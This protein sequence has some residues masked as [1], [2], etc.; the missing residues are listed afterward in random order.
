MRRT[1]VASHPLANLAARMNKVSEV[2]GKV[3]LPR[4]FLGNVAE[5]LRDLNV[6]SSP[7]SSG[8]PRNPRLVFAVSTADCLSISPPFLRFQSSSASTTEPAS[9]VAA[10]H[11]P[12]YSAASLDE[13]SRR[14]PAR[15]SSSSINSSPEVDG[16]IP[17]SGHFVKSLRRRVMASSFPNDGARQPPPIPILPTSSCR[18]KYRKPAIAHMRWLYSSLESCRVSSGSCSTNSTSALTC[19]SSAGLTKCGAFGGKKTSI[20][21]TTS[22]GRAFGI[23]PHPAKY[24]R[25]H[26]S[27][28][29]YCSRKFADIHL[30]AGTNSPPYRSTFRALATRI[31]RPS[32]V[33]FEVSHQARRSATSEV[34]AV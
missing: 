32:S 16:R 8:L 10:F 20:S 25:A 29:T 17:S 7:Q 18:T 30:D 22:L 6:A 5:L 23:A 19:A 11:C 21:F 3:G 34:S 4:G 15:S 14:K 27:R 1:A 31:S 33:F 12:L 2:L 9:T 24:T 28:S 13:M 26:Q